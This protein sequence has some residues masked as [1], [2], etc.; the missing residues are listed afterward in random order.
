MTSL[1]G[2]TFLH[3]IVRYSIAQ[4][5]LL[6]QFL[7]YFQACQL[8][9]MNTLMNYATRKP[10]ALRRWARCGCGRSQLQQPSGTIRSL[11]LWVLIGTYYPLNA[12][13]NLLVDK[14]YDQ[15]Q[16]LAED[17]SLHG[18]ERL[19]LDRTNRQGSNSMIIAKLVDGA[20]CTTQ[21]IMLTKPETE[22][23]EKV[24]DSIKEDLVERVAT[25]WDR[26]DDHE[27]G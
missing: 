19:P 24:D 21:C 16:R 25:V 7:E 1:D 22:T 11:G 20:E 18:M 8:S 27:D 9:D 10:S 2:P 15:L 17:R 14:S 12:R 5:R 23:R 3:P 6:Q 13:Q 26:R 4:R